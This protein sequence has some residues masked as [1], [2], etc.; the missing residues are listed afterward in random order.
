MAE[1]LNASVT[2]FH[3]DGSVDI[4]GNEQLLQ[5]L[6]NSGSD[7]VVVLGSTGEFYNLTLDQAK[8]VIDLAVR[9]VGGK[10]KILAGITRINFDETIELAHYAQDAGVDGLLCVP[11]Y[12]F[13]LPED[14]LLSY[15]RQILS[16]VDHDFYLYNFPACTGADITPEI[17]HTL[18]SEFSQVKGYKDTTSEYGHTRSICQKMLPDFPDFKVYSG[19]DECLVFNAMVGGA[20]CIGGLTNLCPEL[21]AQW[22]QAVNTKDWKTVEELHIKVNRLMELFSI[23]TPFYRA[24]KHAMKLRG[25]IVSDKSLAPSDCVSQE[26]HERIVELLKDLDLL[27]NSVG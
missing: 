23:A 12:Y 21:F 22:T 27:D 26:E 5:H 11:P 24:V 13:A 1:F 15:Y 18:K 6:Y 4:E 16:K 14:S 19:F 9:A 3:E 2:L 7:G 20:G 25:L 8:S 17:C 10:M